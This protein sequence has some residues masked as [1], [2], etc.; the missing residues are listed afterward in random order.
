M[1]VYLENAYIILPDFF[2]CKAKELPAK[3]SALAA[4]VQ[5]IEKM[6]AQRQQYKMKEG[7]K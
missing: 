7:I 6:Q 3:M 4:H 5:R 1:T 2:P